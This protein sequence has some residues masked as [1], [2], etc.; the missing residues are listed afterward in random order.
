MYVFF[1]CHAA[2]FL[3]IGALN[4]WQ[5]VKAATNVI[6]AYQIWASRKML[7][8]HIFLCLTLFTTLGSLYVREWRTKLLF[9]G[10][11]GFYALV[12][13]VS[14]SRGFWISGMFAMFVILWLLDKRKLAWFLLYSIIAAV[15]F[16][17]AVQVVFPD[18]ATFIFKVLKARFASSATG[19]QD[20]SLLSR[21]YETQS[22][23]RLLGYH[24]I[25]GFGLGSPF[26]AYDPISKTFYTATF[27]HNGYLFIWLKLG[28][29]FFLAY[30][31]FW[32]YMM[33]RA[34]RVA[35]AATTPMV[36][37][38]T[39][40]CVACLTAFWLLNI[41][42]SI[43]EGRDGFYC[44]SMCFAALGFAESLEEREK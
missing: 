1:A 38:L 3:F 22:V 18:K 37:I 42:S 10:L 17:V 24:W 5:Y 26:Y 8:T 13:V 2:V 32:A 23:L 16:T 14:F 9:V 28:L 30:F 7:N 29:A 33:R 19:T 12:V 21:Y 31:V 41:T 15:L 4:V 6:Y 43:S 44:L 11:A 34:Y 20:V 39:A 40:G 35:R 36:K 25:G 27:I